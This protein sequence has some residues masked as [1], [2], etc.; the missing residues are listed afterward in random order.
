MIWSR[1]MG[2]LVQA[3]KTRSSLRAD[4]IRLVAAEAELRRAQAEILDLRS[5]LSVREE[6]EPAPLTTTADEPDLDQPDD[7]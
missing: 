2:G 5:Q 6:K 7:V 1:A 3:S 4:S